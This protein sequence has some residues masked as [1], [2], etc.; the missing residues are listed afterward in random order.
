[1]KSTKAQQ[2]KRSRKSVEEFYG[3]P[4]KGAATAWEEI[5]R[6]LAKNIC[7]VGKDLTEKMSTRKDVGSRYMLPKDYFRLDS[8]GDFTVVT[9]REGC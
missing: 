1:M 2:R 9:H 5:W 6:S 8:S 4:Q 3:Q 7:S